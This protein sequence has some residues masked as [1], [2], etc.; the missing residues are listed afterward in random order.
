MN[1]AALLDEKNNAVSFN[2]GG[3]IKIFSRGISGWTVIKEI[4]FN[5]DS[6]LSLKG[7][8]DSI[9]EM[10]IQLTEC[11]VFAAEDVTGIPY[12][13]LESFGFNIW[14]VNGEPKDFLDYIQNNEEEAESEKTTENKDIPVPVETDKKGY[15]CIDLKNVM[16]HNEKVTS[17]QVLLPFLKNCEFEELEVSCTHVPPWFNVEAKKLNFEFQSLEIGQNLFKVKIYHKK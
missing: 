14:R 5:I 11:K 2:E 12:N 6:S 13:I 1:I 4:P 17:K 8:R 10:V 16:E 7:I 15:Y 3:I 9:R